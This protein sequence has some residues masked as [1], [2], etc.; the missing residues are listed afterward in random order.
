MG[1]GPH[2]SSKIVLN[3]A[4]NGNIVVAARSLVGLL[5]GV[6]GTIVVHLTIVVRHHLDTDGL[7]GV[8]G[9]NRHLLRHITC[10][11]NIE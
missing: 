1:D 5:R 8:V 7:I 4:L 6:A 11:V 3:I 9:D 10:G 2:V